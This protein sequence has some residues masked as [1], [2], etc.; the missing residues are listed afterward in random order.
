MSTFVVIEYADVYLQVLLKPFQALIVATFALN[1]L[2]PDLIWLHPSQCTPTPHRLG[3]RL[4][5]L[6]HFQHQQ[7]SKR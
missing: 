6:Y 5:I 7:V 3:T 1:Y 2:H 4:S